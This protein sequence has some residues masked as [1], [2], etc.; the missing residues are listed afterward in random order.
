MKSGTWGAKEPGHNF[1]P[2][3]VTSFSQEGTVTV[4]S[5]SKAH[6]REENYEYMP[7]FLL[8]ESQALR[9]SGRQWGLLSSL[10]R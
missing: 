6:Q 5:H 3:T 10:S 7:A 1:T 8:G 2:E 4:V 9:T